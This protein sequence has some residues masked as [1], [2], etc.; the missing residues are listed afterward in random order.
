MTKI[1]SITYNPARVESKPKKYSKA[2]NR[3]VAGINV[4]T[5]ITINQFAEMVS[6]PNSHTWYGGTYTNTISNQTWTSTQVFGLDFDDGDNTPEETIATLQTNGIYPQLWYT[7]F[8]STKEMHKY[9]VVLFAENQITDIQERDHIYKGLLQLVPHADPT[10]K[11]AGRIFFG[12]QRAAVIHT[13]PISNQQLIDATSIAVITSDKGRTRFIPERNFPSLNA[14]NGKFLSSYNRNNHF[15]PEIIT[16]HPTTIMGGVLPTIDWK[17]AQERVKVLDAFLTG[18]WLYHDQLFGLATNLIYIK[19]GQRLMKET[20][21]RF[22]EEGRTQYT[23]NNFNIITYLKKVQYP[24]KPIHSFSPYPEDADL[25]DLYSAVVDV[26]GRIEIIEPIKRIPLVE[27]EQTFQSKFKEVLNL[28]QDDGIYLFKVPTAIGKTELLTNVNATLAFPTHAL[29]CEVQERMKVPHVLSPDSLHFLDDT[30]NSRLKYYYAAGL[31]QKATA[32]IHDVAN[33]SNTL[34]YNPSDIN[35][36]QVYLEQLKLTQESENTVLTTH[37]RALHLQH[38]HDTI[39][40]DEDPLETILPIQTAQISDLVK[41]QLT[42][43]KLFGKIKLYIKTLTESPSGIPIPTP[44]FPGDPEE[45]IHCT[46]TIHVSSNLIGLLTSHYYFKDARDNNTLHYIQQIPLPNKKRIIVLSATAPVEIYRA[47]FGDRL[48]VIELTDVEQQGVII[49]NTKQSCARNAMQR[50]APSLSEKVGDVPVITF[51]RFRSSFKNPVAD[52][53]FG[54]CS[55]YDNL[56]GKDIAVVGT[57]HRNNVLYHLIAAQINGANTPIH[58]MYYQKVEYN[59]F[60]FKF[61]CFD[62]PLLRNIQLSLIE[63]CLLQAV[64]R[65]RTL[66]TNATVQVYSNFPLRATTKF[67][68]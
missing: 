44:S 56:K 19:G 6:A 8:S 15:S 49:Q 39:I 37:A 34:Q 14:E 38:K 36:A 53:Y 32:M 13:E 67:I 27:A 62:D 47:L 10:C 65:A 30:L 43:T 17:K 29:K 31:I 24:A 33:T 40:F 16:P 52:M 48:K 51:K 57:P 2:M 21:Q 68:F 1:Y 25:H 66:R 63:S 60:R 23:E 46:S 55:G 61:N 28:S 12:G 20:M 18:E 59:G 11:N 7:T 4:P 58:S 50:Y 45:L 26:R 42:S 3:H 5:G 9:R 54:N 41:I 64:G 22:N 35:Q